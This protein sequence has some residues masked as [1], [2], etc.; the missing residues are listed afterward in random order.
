MTD[1][2]EEPDD[3]ITRIEAREQT[4]ETDELMG[5]S[6]VGEEK[7]EALREA[8]F[9]TTDDLRRA[10]Q[11]ALAGVEGIPNALAARIKADVGG[12]GVAEDA[13]DDREAP[14]RISERMLA[15]ETLPYVKA[16]YRSSDDES[17]WV[18]GVAECVEQPLIGNGDVVR[19]ALV[20]NAPKVVDLPAE[21]VGRI[22]YPDP[23]EQLARDDREDGDE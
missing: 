17:A 6:G 1:E 9:E 14:A 21:T 8:G 7:A 18:R 15:D 5:V 20:N 22:D 19:V 16:F 23:P 3:T 2:P 11:S 13:P 12:L 10:E 4:D